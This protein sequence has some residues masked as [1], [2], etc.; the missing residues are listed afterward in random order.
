M[1]LRRV[2]GNPGTEVS[3]EE[4]KEVHEV[5]HAAHLRPNIA[6][7]GSKHADSGIFPGRVIIYVLDLSF[8]KGISECT[9]RQGRIYPPLKFI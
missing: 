1:G 2:F 6:V 4:V 7:R 5:W 9:R 8:S 3:N